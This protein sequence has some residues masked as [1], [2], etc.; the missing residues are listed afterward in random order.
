VDALAWIGGCRAGRT[1]EHRVLRLRVGGSERATLTAPFEGWVA[2][3]QHSDRPFP[4]QLELRVV[5]VEPGAPGEHPYLR[6][7]LLAC[8]TRAFDGV[9]LIGGQARLAD[10]DVLGPTLSDRS[11][12]SE[13]SDVKLVQGDASWDFGRTQ[14]LPVKIGTFGPC[15]SQA[16][17]DFAGTG[18][19]LT[20]RAQAA[21]QHLALFLGNDTPRQ[22]LVWPL[23]GGFPG[24]PATNLGDFHGGHE[25]SGDW[26][27][28]PTL[29]K[30]VGAG[31]VAAR[32]AVEG[33]VP[34]LQDSSLV[35]WSSGHPLQ[36]SVRVMNV[37]RMASAQQALTN[38]GIGLGIGGSLLASLLFEWTRSRPTEVPQP[39]QRT[40]EEARTV[41]LSSRDRRWARVATVAGLLVLVRLLWRSR[42][43]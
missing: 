1:R 17:E 10:V 43:R 21:I 41:L 23:V 14:I 15:V 34:P 18:Y 6:Y 31:S 12:V 20:G 8:G 9:L 13:L 19:T 3:L 25:L 22:S 7:S 30:Q 36:P 28:P 40:V 26:V 29:H 11:L 32:T 24:V 38:S 16:G 5:A 37:D 27:I 39:P 42:R 35:T 33:A 4:E 2:V